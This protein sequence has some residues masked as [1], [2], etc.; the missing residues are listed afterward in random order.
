MPPTPPPVFDALVAYGMTALVLLVAVLWVALFSRGQL[1]RAA[2]LAA[3]VGAVMAVSALA[4][5]T[6]LLQRNGLRPP[7]M[8]VMIVLVFVMAFW[9]GLSPFGLASARELPLVALIG[10]QGFRLP[11]E[12]VVMHRAA[13]LGIMP[14]E[15]SYSGYN[16]DIVTGIGAIAL[17]ALLGMGVRVPRAVVW[18]WNLWGCWCLAVITF[19][20]IATSPMVRLFGEAPHVN[21]WV[22]FVPYV[23]LPVVLVTAALFGHI[24]ITR[25]LM[26]TR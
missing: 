7:P 13:L 22:L 5:W 12:D 15:L 4:A 16:F 8:A 17:S 3:A 25:K 2:V 10:L 9:A 11:L 24:V 14:V 21:T 23:W 6:G 26:M 19:I 1:R 18:A 20:A